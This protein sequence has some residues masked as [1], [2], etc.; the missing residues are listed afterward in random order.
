MRTSNKVFRHRPDT[1]K[2]TD[3]ARAHAEAW[4]A[5]GFACIG[6]AFN[7]VDDPDLRWQ[8]DKR[9]R[10]SVHGELIR[11]MLAFRTGK[12]ELRAGAVAQDDGKFQRFLSTVAGQGA[13]GRAGTR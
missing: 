11:L 4:L 12:L 8:W 2:T 7:M 5:D 10:D 13:G 9:T 6:R 1:V 3:D